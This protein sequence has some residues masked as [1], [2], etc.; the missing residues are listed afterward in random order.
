MRSIV[1][2]IKHCIGKTILSEN[3]SI[4]LLA[5]KYNVDEF[6]QNYIFKCL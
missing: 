6:L 4:T 2:M 5:Y 1:I 3:D